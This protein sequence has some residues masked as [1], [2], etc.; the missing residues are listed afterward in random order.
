MAHDP[1]GMEA[2]ILNEPAA[3][4][5][6]TTHRPGNVESGTIRFEGFRIMKRCSEYIVLD[7]NF[8]CLQE[9][10]NQTAAMTTLSYRIAIAEEISVAPLI[11]QPPFKSRK[12]ELILVKP[13]NGEGGSFWGM[14]LDQLYPG[15][16]DWTCRRLTDQEFADHIRYEL[17]EKERSRDWSADKILA[18]H[19]GVVVST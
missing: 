19:K 3:C 7:S 9:G 8:Q 16:D 2:P 15:S 10:I 4:T 11:V 5:G 1:R 17:L 13:V 6:T 14:L 18:M 12:G